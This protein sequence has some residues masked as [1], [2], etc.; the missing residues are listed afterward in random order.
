[1]QVLFFIKG[2]IRPL[3]FPKGLV[4]VMCDYV[5]GLT[6]YFWLLRRVLLLS[7]TYLDIV[8]PQN[9]KNQNDQTS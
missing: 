4:K 5:L 2:N 3:M 1:M 7:E 9:G 6:P 8:F